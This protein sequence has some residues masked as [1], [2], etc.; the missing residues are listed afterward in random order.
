ML[1][2][3]R[4]WRR[5]TLI[6]KLPEELVYMVEDNIIGDYDTLAKDNTN[7]IN[8]LKLSNLFYQEM[9]YF[10]I[11]EAYEAGEFE[12]RHKIFNKHWTNDGNVEDAY[13]ILLKSIY[14]RNLPRKGWKRFFEILIKNNR[15]DLIKL[16]LSHR[17][18]SNMLYLDFKVNIDDTSRNFHK[19]LKTVS[20]EYSKY[21]DL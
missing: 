1:N 6:K 3:I 11:D 19:L 15:E 20:T 12:Q 18:L 17:K 7:L 4:I 16:L 13:V 21:P 2:K 10:E 8:A 9:N 14:H 5:S